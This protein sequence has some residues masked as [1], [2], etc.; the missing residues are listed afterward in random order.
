MRSGTRGKTTS[1]AKV[2]NISE[3][4]FWMLIDEEELFVEFKKFPWFKDASIA[5]LLM[6]KRPSP[7]HLQWP[8]LDVDL[9]LESLR[10]P[11]KFPLVS[12]APV[13][14]PRPV[15]QAARGKAGGRARRAVGR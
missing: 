14:P 15:T 11:E 9:A 4:G 7:H 8:A 12:K 13:R 2:T 1:S 6:V 3:N 5:Q 10:H